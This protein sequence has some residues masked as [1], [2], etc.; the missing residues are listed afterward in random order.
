MAQINVLVCD[1]CEQAATSRRAVFQYELDAV[2]EGERS[3]V[4]HADVHGWDCF[5]RVISR[6]RKAERYAKAAEKSAG[7]KPKK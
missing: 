3:K 5:G 2:F 1:G 7:K 6:R 4:I